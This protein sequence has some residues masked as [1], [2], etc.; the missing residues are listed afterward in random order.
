MLSL[1]ILVFFNP[2]A[3]SQ[4]KDSFI[5]D[6]LLSVQ[7]YKKGIAEG[8]LGDYEGAINSFN[9]VYRIYQKLYGSNSPLLAYPLTNLGIQYKNLR[10]LDKAIEI[11]KKAETLYIGAFGENYPLLG[12][13][14]ANMANIYRNTGDYS[15][16]LEYQVNA[17]RILCKDSVKLNIG[18]QNAKFNIAEVRL[19]LGQNIEAIRFAKSNLK[20]TLP[21]LKPRIF[22]LIALA[23]RNEGQFE[24]SNENYLNS[25]KSWI[26]LYGD[27]NVELV[28][29]YLAYSSFL[30]L[31]KQFEKAFLYSGKAQT[32]VLKFFGEK[33]V[34]YSEVQTN[35]G[36]YYYQKNIA[37]QKID[38]FRS[39]QKANLYKAIQYYQNAIISLVGSFDIK[40]PLVDPPLKNIISEIQLVDA[41]KKKAL[42]MEKIG[43]IFRS[44]FDSKNAEKYFNASLSSLSKAT[45]LIHRLRIGFE[46]EESK[47]FF[48]KNQ[49][50]TFFDAIR[51]SNKMYQQTKDEQFV[52]MAFGFSERSKASNL[53]ASVKDVKAKEFGEIPDSLLQRENYLKINVANYTSML[54]EENNQQKPDSQRVNLYN[55]K[56]FKLN[57]EYDQL[58][59]YF[60]KSYPG[61]YSYKYENRIISIKEVQSKLRSRDALIEYVVNE[62]GSK[63]DVG[64]LYRFV[65][66]KDAVNFSM[67]VIDSTYEQNIDFVHA[68]LTGQ[69]YLFTKKKDYVHYSLSGYNLYKKLIKPVFYMIDG[70]DLTIMPDDKLSYIPFDALLTQLPDTNKMDFRNLNYLIRDFAINYSY[71]ATLLYDFQNKNKR[72][73]NDL[74]AFSPEYI[75]TELR[76]DRENSEKYFFSPLLGAEEEVKNISK[77]INTVAFAGSLAQESTF[78]DKAPDFD[79]LHLAM[80]TII[81]DSLP[82]F[83]KLVFSKPDKNSSDDGFLNT[84]EIYNI[85]LNAR[86]AVLSACET[87]SGKLQ[88]GEGVMSLARGFIY[89][90]CPS[91]VMTLWPVEDKSG[92]EIMTSFY[93]YLAKGKRKDVALRMA[94]LKHLELSDPLM[95]HPHYWL[96]YVSIGNQE[97]L[98]LSKDVYFIIF[99]FIAIIGVFVDRYYRKKKAH[100]N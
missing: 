76:T 60:E 11:Y 21:R 25:I 95:A 78:K 13:V 34:A 56:I 86:L 82:M 55:S 71:S 31:Q 63:K 38:D 80:H 24:L 74:I 88:K 42:A 67:E 75:A 73:E 22:D 27:A 19:K 10:S 70:K 98:Y 79:I 57:R 40:N 26:D 94:K 58:I 66:T 52:N 46:N 32:I 77:S 16:A 54:F 91:I 29:E 93:S 85:K 2:F 68:F 59:K 7:L 48:S 15:K 3:F 87:G 28:D 65:I 49:E 39:Q 96:G 4:K 30:L 64:E 47:L 90:G 61:Y 53:L 5:Q 81:N 92:A 72:S 36:D 99:L 62:P 43:D 84:Y 33:S 23:Y 44:E 6:S 8:R 51:I 50:S 45:Q 69:N 37:A 12:A 9:Q 89:A 20:T 18:F 83:S 35:F 97:P 17:Y 14:Y 1:I 100:R 41:F